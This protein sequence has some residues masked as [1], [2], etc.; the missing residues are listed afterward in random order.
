LIRDLQAMSI[1]PEQKRARCRQVLDDWKAFGHSEAALRK[2]G[3]S[4]GKS[5]DRR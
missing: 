3:A 1:P 2:L 5:S 4:K